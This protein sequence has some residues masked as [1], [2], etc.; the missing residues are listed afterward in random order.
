[1]AEAGF[2]EQSSLGKLSQRSGLSQ[3]S[4]G[5]NRLELNEFEIGG[6]IVAGDQLGLSRQERSNSRTPRTSQTVNR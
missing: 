4:L 5:L 6:K 1:M 3:L 2:G